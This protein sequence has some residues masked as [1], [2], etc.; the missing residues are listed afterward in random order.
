M[1][2]LYTLKG[3][4][5]CVGW[6]FT[7]IGMM[8]IAVFFANEYEEMGVIPAFIDSA[9]L[10]GIPLIIGWIIKRFAKK[11]S[12]EYYRSRRQDNGG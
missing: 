11:M 5:N 3:A 6:V 12:G 9:I 8:V 1:A 2:A 10:G 4:V 7:G